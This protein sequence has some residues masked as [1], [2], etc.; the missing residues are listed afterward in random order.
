MSLDSLLDEFIMFLYASWRDGVSDTARPT[1]PIIDSS[2]FLYA[3]WRDGVS[4]KGGELCPW[5]NSARK[6]VFLYASWR[7]GVSDP[8]LSGRPVTSGLSCP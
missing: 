8:T 6:N 7:D 2:V 3:S 1:T 4:D 5:T